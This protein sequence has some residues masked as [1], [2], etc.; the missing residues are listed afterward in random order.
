MWSALFGVICRNQEVGQR[1]GNRGI[2]EN[3]IQDSLDRSGIVL[4][5]ECLLQ[6]VEAIESATLKNAVPVVLEEADQ[7][8]EVDSRFRSRQRADLRTEL[9]QGKA[10]RYEAPGGRSAYQIKVAVNGSSAIASRQATSE[11]TKQNSWNQTSNSA[12]ID[13]Q[14]ANYSTGTISEQTVGS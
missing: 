6:V 11:L 5:G 9:G 8:I 14:N 2:A 12:P 7:T 3:L 4:L 13:G 1:V 10:E